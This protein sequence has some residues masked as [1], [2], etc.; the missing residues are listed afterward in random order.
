MSE[1]T[2]TLHFHVE[3][4]S[5]DCDGRLDRDYITTINEGEDEYG[6]KARVLSSLV[7]WSYENRVVFNDEDSEGGTEIEV[8]YQH[9]EGR[10]YGEARLC[11][12]EDCDHSKAGQRDH[13]A[14]AMG[15]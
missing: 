5:T 7:S 13:Y 11:R 1:N 3:T 6:F 9:D 2:S 15:Y 14:E 8:S 10:F 4:S 12:N